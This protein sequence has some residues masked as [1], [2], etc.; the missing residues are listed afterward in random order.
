MAHK[1]A[2]AWFRARRRLKP[3]PFNSTSWDWPE[4][5]DLDSEWRNTTLDLVWQPNEYIIEEV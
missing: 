4:W 1:K 3:S 5:Y 2:V